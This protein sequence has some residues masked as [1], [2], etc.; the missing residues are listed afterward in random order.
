MRLLETAVILLCA[1]TVMGSALDP[2]FRAVSSASGSFLVITDAEYP[3]ELPAS[4][5]RATLNVVTGTVHS[6]FSSNTYWDGPSWRVIFMKG[7][8]FLSGCPLSLISDDGEFLV[9]VGA[10]YWG[11]ALRIYHATKQEREG[12][13][14]RDIELKEIWPSDK[15]QP[16]VF[17]DGT[18]HWFDGGTFKF[19][20]DSR[21]LIHKTR[22]GNIVR[23][24]LSDGS[25]VH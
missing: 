17:T 19:S 3:H 2:C 25:V 15:Q 7:D 5:T 10:G 9:L 14:V 6:A 11:A 24:R 16:T 13:L 12:A 8:S 4:A 20:S 18:P 1:S 22:W 21:F 23:I